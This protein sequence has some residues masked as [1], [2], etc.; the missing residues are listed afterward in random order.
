MAPNKRPA[1]RVEES[2]GR[3]GK[4]TK[5]RH[6]SAVDRPL[7]R[8]EAQDEESNESDAS[9]QVDSKWQCVAWAHRTVGAARFEEAETALTHSKDTYVGSLLHGLRP[10]FI[11]HAHSKKYQKAGTPRPSKP[12]ASNDASVP[13]EVN[14]KPVPINQEIGL[15]GTNIKVTGGIATQLSPVFIPTIDLMRGKMLSFLKHHI[16]GNDAID[17]QYM[18][19]DYQFAWMTGNTWQISR[20]ISNLINE[21]DK[22]KPEMESNFSLRTKQLVNHD[23]VKQIRTLLSGF[24]GYDANEKAA[25]EDLISAL[26]SGPVLEAIQFRPK[27]GDTHHRCPFS[28]LPAFPK[29]TLDAAI[30]SEPLKAVI[31]KFMNVNMWEFV[32]SELL[33]LAALTWGYFWD[34]ENEELTTESLFHAKPI[35]SEGF[36]PTVFMGY[37]RW[38]LV[39]AEVDRLAFHPHPARFAAEAAERDTSNGIMPLKK[40]ITKEELQA[41]LRAIGENASLKPACSFTVP[42][43]EGSQLPKYADGELDGL[44]PFKPESGSHREAIEATMALIGDVYKIA[45]T[46]FVG[47]AK[48]HRVVPITSSHAGRV[49]EFDED[50]LLDIKDKFQDDLGILTFPNIDPDTL[51]V[52]GTDIYALNSDEREQ[53]EQGGRKADILKED[54]LHLNSPSFEFMEST[55]LKIAG[56]QGVSETEKDELTELLKSEARR[57][58]IKLLHTS[59]SPNPPNPPE[60]LNPLDPPDPLDRQESLNPPNPPGLQGP[61]VSSEISSDIGNLK[62]EDNIGQLNIGDLKLKDIIGQ[63]KGQQ[64]WRKFIQDMEGR[65]MMEGL[66]YQTTSGIPIADPNYVHNEILR[67]Q[68]YLAKSEL[69]AEGYLHKD[70]LKALFADL[71]IKEGEHYVWSSHGDPVYLHKIPPIGSKTDLQTLL[72]EL[73]AEEGEHYRWEGDMPVFMKRLQTTQQP[74]TAE[75]GLD[76]LCKGTILF[77]YA[78][79]TDKD[80]KLADETVIVNAT[81]TRIPAPFSADQTLLSALSH[82][83]NGTLPD[84]GPFVQNFHTVYTQVVLHINQL[85]DLLQKGVDPSHSLAA[86][87]DDGAKKLRGLMGKLY[88]DE[89]LEASFSA[90]MTLSAILHDLTQPRAKVLRPAYVPIV[91]WLRQIYSYVFVA[92][93]AMRRLAISWNT[94]QSADKQISEDLYSIDRIKETWET[95]TLLVDTCKG[96]LDLEV[97]EDWDDGCPP[98]APAYNPHSLTFAVLT[99][100]LDGYI[101]TESIPKS[102]YAL[103]VAAGAGRTKTL[104]DEAQ[105][106]MVVG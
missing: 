63:L 90:P 85:F 106:A 61:Q 28:S 91:A 22:L 11:R 24:P 89:D 62:L 39:R 55:M 31:Q 36:D 25:V 66:S 76:N 104:L 51:L 17:L 88:S 27:H 96:K 34:R 81:K 50:S 42:D 57:L 47:P 38:L 103:A 67:G 37:Y 70:S 86:L 18:V 77:L 54:I 46:N 13:S 23:L 41:A 40:L 69:K 43:L 45:A 29:A 52:E 93:L 80:S 74:A 19:R 73:G 56:G 21:V 97:D 15:S 71:G 14:L 92:G 87:G 75:Q 48:G 44:P 100:I 3:P 68:G 64:Q 83:K 16:N 5:R 26:S 8:R 9:R 79:L 30:A 49:L 53:V 6:G 59:N 4:R 58:H 105:T 32:R 101:S 35:P 95:F 60:S 33:V 82:L 72:A 65:L 2:H 102:D 98:S 94:V 99:H 78:G 84:A 12:L 20:T 7:R 1:A 10:A